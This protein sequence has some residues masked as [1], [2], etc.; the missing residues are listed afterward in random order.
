[1]LAVLRSRTEFERA[2]C[3]R[4]KLLLSSSAPRAQRHHQD[5]LLRTELQECKRSHSQ[6]GFSTVRSR[7][8]QVLYNHRASTLTTFGS[9]PEAYAGAPKRSSL[10]LFTGRSHPSLN[11]FQALLWPPSAQMCDRQA[12]GSAASQYISSMFVNTYRGKVQLEHAPLSR[13]L[14]HVKRRSG[15]VAAL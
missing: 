3:L 4:L 5:V 13:P 12:R 1:M 6:D 8:R 14:S 11:P 10:A 9:R 7:R 15:P 2:R